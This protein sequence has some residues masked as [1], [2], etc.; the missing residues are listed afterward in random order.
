MTIQLFMQKRKNEEE[1]NFSILYTST[2]GKKIA[3][4]NYE[5]MAKTGTFG[6]SLSY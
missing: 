6:S 1:A 5:H 2:S 3:T 4:A